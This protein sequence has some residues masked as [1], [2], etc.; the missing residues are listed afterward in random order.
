MKYVHQS[1]YVVYFVNI[2]IPWYILTNCVM[3]FVFCCSFLYFSISSSNAEIYKSIQAC[4]FES[5]EIFHV[6]SLIE[7]ALKSN[8][9]GYRGFE[10]DNS[11][12]IL[13]KNREIC[14]SDTPCPKKS[15]FVNEKVSTFQLS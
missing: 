5:A 8:L 12:C 13:Y 7:C 1:N 11:L 14:P 4:V 15:I 3:N 2:S 6:S 9:N 10:F